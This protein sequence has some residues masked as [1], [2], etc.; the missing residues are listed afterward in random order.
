MC[1]PRADTLVFPYRSIVQKP[2]WILLIFVTCLI[3][4]SCVLTTTAGSFHLDN[5]E[6]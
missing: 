5:K 2:C 4:H 6:R 3:V 1:A